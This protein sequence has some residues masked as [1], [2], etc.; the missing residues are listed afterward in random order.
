M[1]TFT[2]AIL[3]WLVIA[4][5]GMSVGYAYREQMEVTCTRAIQ[6]VLSL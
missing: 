3:P 4:L 1:K 2:T 5:A 6:N